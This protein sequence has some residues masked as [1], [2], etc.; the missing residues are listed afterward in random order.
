MI[1]F[2]KTNMFN[3]VSIKH[4]QMSVIVHFNYFW[5]YRGFF[6]ARQP[7]DVLLDR[8]PAFKPCANA[9]FFSPVVFQG[10]TNVLV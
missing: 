6:L 9:F 7:Q 8:F 3:H 5:N 1:P 2:P 10:R 4:K